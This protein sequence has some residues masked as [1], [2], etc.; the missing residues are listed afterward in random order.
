MFLFLLRGKLKNLWA[1]K[2]IW[3]FLAFYLLSGHAGAHGLSWC[4][5]ADG[6]GHLE[7]SP[8]ACVASAPQTSCED[9]DACAQS[10]LAQSSHHHSTDECRH[11]PVTADQASFVQGVQPLQDV[12]PA[13]AT[14]DFL[15][16]RLRLAAAI[17]DSGSFPVFPDLPRSQAL[18]ALASIVLLN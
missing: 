8:S 14:S 11:Q 3:L 7:R 12:S 1:K 6:H 13:D 5:G 15:R 18:I 17:R 16:S 2:L 9:A 10:V 4:L